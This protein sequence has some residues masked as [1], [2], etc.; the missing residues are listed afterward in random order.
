[1]S[2]VV[3]RPQGGYMVVQHDG[4]VFCYD[5]APFLGSIP[6]HPEWKLGG[7]VAGGAWSESGAGYWLVARDGAV[8]AFGDAGYYGGVN[9]ETP[10]TRGSRYAVGIARI[11]PKS[12]RIITFDPS[13]DGTPYDGYAYINPCRTPPKAGPPGTAA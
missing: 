8:Y 11:S 1:M 2:T 6:Q 7:N 9:T 12:Y 13:D 3:T 4:G 5:G 10:Q